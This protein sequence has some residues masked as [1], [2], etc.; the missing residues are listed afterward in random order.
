M[1]LTTLLLGSIIATSAGVAA[2]DVKVKVTPERAI[3][4]AAVLVSV[5]GAGDAPSGKAGGA[6]LHFF[7]SRG[8]YQAV[9]AIPLDQQPGRFE[10]DVTGA[11]APA[12]V[13]VK[14][15]VFPEASL[16]VEDE[17][18]N[19][20]PQE[21]TRIDADN[22][23]IRAA[24]MESTGAPKFTGKFSPAGRGKV[25]SVYGEWR[26]FNDGHRSQHLGL[27]VDARRGSAVRA[28]ATGKV[29]LVRDCFLAGNVI[30][31]VHGAG[32]ATAFYHL[33]DTTVREGDIVR[34]GTKL[35]TVGATGRTT[36]AH[37][38]TSIWVAGGFVDPASFLR[39]ALRPAR[40]QITRR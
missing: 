35:G 8:G 31:V 6:K 2:A 36:G 34:A 32:I 4:G 12:V 1:R 25:T 28:P 10:V 33:E 16:V 40:P 27:D 24:M 3:P 11:A 23:A 13:N 5:T 7:A 22:H 26:T 37:L 29:T 14:E 17:L 30:V 19:P 39:L 20:G 18:A 38:H 15:H 9:A 21:R